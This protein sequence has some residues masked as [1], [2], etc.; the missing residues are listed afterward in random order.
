MQ[1]EY[2]FYLLLQ[3]PFIFDND[4][5]ALIEK[6]EDV[7]FDTRNAGESL[8]QAAKVSGKCKVSSLSE[9]YTLGM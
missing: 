4:F 2:L 8:F 1:V 3:E 5:P 9:A 6:D 7:T